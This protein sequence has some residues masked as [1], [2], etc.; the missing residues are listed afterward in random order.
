MD[1]LLRLLGRGKVEEQ[2]S[3][4]NR[5][6]KFSKT[7]DAIDPAKTPWGIVIRTPVGFSVGAK[8]SRTIPLGLKCDT[9]LLLI[10]GGGATVA[11]PSN[12]DVKIVMPDQS[13]DLTIVNDTDRIFEVGDRQVVFYAIPLGGDFDV[14]SE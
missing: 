4:K 6:V 11:A 12:Q 1:R 9:P 13:I 3:K 2:M 14:E 7:G 10:R 8:M 5:I